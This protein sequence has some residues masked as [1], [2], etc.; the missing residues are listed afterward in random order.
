VSSQWGPPHSLYKRHGVKGVVMESVETINIQT[1]D[2][3]CDENNITF[4][5]LLKVDV[6]GHELA[7]FKGAQKMLS[8]HRIGCIQFEYG[9]C[10]L[11]ARVY[12]LDI[13]N[14]LTAF[15]YEIAK[16]YP[17]NLKYLSNYDQTFETF[18]Y[19]N[20]VALLSKES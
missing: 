18:R 5:N 10:N 15:E 16:I 19:S 4:I 12:L 7:V 6:E 20:Y 9:G 8:E 11:D 14:Y 1:L 13:W 17:N 2:T 3:Y